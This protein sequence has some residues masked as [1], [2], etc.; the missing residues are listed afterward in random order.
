MSAPV[1]LTDTVEPAF[2]CPGRTT[3][4]DI[5]AYTE[6]ELT[7][8]QASLSSSDIAGFR[9][10]EHLLPNGDL[11]SGSLLGNMPESSGKYIWSD[12]CI[13]EGEWR[14]GMRHGHGKTQW[15][16]GA[17]YDLMLSLQ[18]GIRNLREMFKID[19]ADYMMSICGN[20]ALRVLSSPGKSGRVTKKLWRKNTKDKF[21]EVERFWRI[22]KEMIKLGVVYKL[23]EGIAKWLLD[24]IAPRATD[25]ERSLM[26]GFNID[27]ELIEIYQNE[28]ETAQPGVLVWLRLMAC[29]QLKW[30][31]NYNV[32]PREISAA[33]DKFTS[34]LQRIYLN[35]PD[36][37][38][39]IRLIMET[40]GRGGHG[41]LGQR[42]RDEILLIQYAITKFAESFEMVPKTVAENVRL[43]S[44]EIIYSLYA[45]H[46]AGNSKVGINLEEGVCKDVSVLN[47]WD[48]YVTKAMMAERGPISR[49]LVLR[50]TQSKLIDTYIKEKHQGEITF[51][52]KSRVGRGGMI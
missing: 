22:F 40:V 36:H 28:G 39:I 14:R 46:A 4:L 25:A 42:I 24:E 33:R 9:V 13:Y 47:V 34:S 7:N 51:G 41:D 21:V 27:T 30:N 37:R 38:E 3:S 29:K 49:W 19:A 50:S 16:S 8:G 2:S 11:Y 6:K 48:L 43:N 44:M 10:G 35:Q 20:D 32:K 52:G 26:H 31:K 1:G 45:E 23:S 5:F 15:P 18:L 12:G 17:V